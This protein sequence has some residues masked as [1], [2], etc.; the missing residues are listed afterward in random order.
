MA[1]PKGMSPLSEVRLERSIGTD[2][3][4]GKSKARNGDTPPILVDNVPVSGSEPLP[5]AGHHGLGSH[6]KGRSSKKGTKPS[7]SSNTCGTAKSSVTKSLPE[8]KAK[9][10]GKQKSREVSSRYKESAKSRAV[11]SRTKMSDSSCLSI[12]QSKLFLTAVSSTPVSA[13]DKVQ[14]ATVGSRKPPKMASLDTTVRQR[15]SVN[16]AA[17]KDKAAFKIKKHDK[18]DTVKVKPLP[19]EVP[20]KKLTT[21][22]EHVLEHQLLYNQYLQWACLSQMSEASI[23]SEQLHCSLQVRQLSGLVDTVWHNCMDLERK[24]QAVSIYREMVWLEQQLGSILTAM[25]GSAD[26]VLADLTHLATTLSATRNQLQLK[27]CLQAGDGQLLVDELVC[28][29]E[30]CMAA[31]SALNSDVSPHS[32][33]LQRTSDAVCSL[34]QALS[35]SCQHMGSCSEVLQELSSLALQEASLSVSDCHQ[36]EEKQH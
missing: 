6:V 5:D 17:G 8:V 10:T 14:E 7:H 30:R 22:G 28:A 31:L 2:Q 27:D 11:A 9:S 25:S 29:A 19:A 21:D 3:P 32:S 13:G 34:Q 24:V 16:A 1:D 4:V 36:V 35:D 26:A 15:P 20:V 23:N 18:A 33:L 12:N